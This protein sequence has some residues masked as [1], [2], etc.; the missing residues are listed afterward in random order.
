MKIFSKSFFTA[1]LIIV[2]MIIWEND[3]NAQG[4]YGP[5]AALLY[6]LAVQ[7]G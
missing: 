6:G 5:V 4:L 2:I 7:T 3:V 1:N